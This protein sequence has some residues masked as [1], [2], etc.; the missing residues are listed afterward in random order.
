MEKDAW[1]AGHELKNKT[2]LSLQAFVE[3]IEIYGENMNILT[4]VTG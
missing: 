3:S 4:V 2:K 1:T